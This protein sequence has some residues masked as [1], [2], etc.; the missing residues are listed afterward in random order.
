MHPPFYIAVT[1]NNCVDGVEDHGLVCCAQTVSDPC[2]RQDVLRTFR[3]RLD[4]LP[5]LPNV[6][7]KI[8]RVGEVAPQF[9]Q[10]ESVRQHLAGMLNKDAQE[11]VFLGRQPHLPLPHLDNPPHEVNRQIAHTKNGTFSLNVE[12]M[13]K[14]SAHPRKQLIHAER[15]CYIIVSSK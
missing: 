8:L 5:E 11:L 14:C 13:P 10:Q 15:L 12:L 6:D 2:F 1:A 4:L 9:P 7:T 3:I